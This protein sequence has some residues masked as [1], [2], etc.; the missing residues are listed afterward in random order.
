MRLPIDTSTI[1]FA[2]AGLAEHEHDHEHELGL[3]EAAGRRL[4]NF[5]SLFDQIQRVSRGGPAEETVT[6]RAGLS[7]GQS[8]RDIDRD[9]LVRSDSADRPLGSQQPLL[10]TV[11]EVAHIT[12]LSRTKIY[13]LLYSGQLTSVKIGA[14]RRIRRVDLQAFVQSLETEF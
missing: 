10:F 11:V 5:E 3:V 8:S 9:I 7:R 12:K 2:T 4:S 14:S 6:S 1:K 13:E